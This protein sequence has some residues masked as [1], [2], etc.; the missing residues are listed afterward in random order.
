[1]LRHLLHRR[2]GEHDIEVIRTFPR[3][4]VT[5]TKLDPV[6]GERRRVVDH[7]RGPINAQHGA[8]PKGLAQGCGQS[9]I[10][11]TQVNH[12]GALYYTNQ[13]NEVPESLL[14]LL[15]EM[16]VLVRVPSVKRSHSQLCREQRRNYDTTLAQCRHLVAAT[17]KSVDRHCGQVFVGAGTAGWPKTVTPCLAI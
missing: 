6:A 12:L 16:V 7:G 14:A 2:V 10:A 11:A 13:M 15:G 9:T 1:V 4:H 17:G 8:R 3:P 5:E